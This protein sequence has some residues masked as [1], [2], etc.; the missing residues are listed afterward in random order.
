MMKELLQSLSMFITVSPE[1]ANEF[2]T[3]GKRNRIN[4]GIILHSSDKICTESHFIISGVLRIYSFRDDKEITEDF[5][6]PGEWCNALRSFMFQQHDIYN[7]E[8]ITDAEIVTI[9]YKDYTSILDQYIEVNKYIRILYDHIFF[10]LLD[11]LTLLRY[12]TAKEKYDIF[13][14]HYNHIQNDIPQYLIASFMGI[15]PET[16]S[17]VRKLK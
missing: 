15:T 13:C 5:N 11:R 7:V 8:A 14:K 2:I 3:K 6:G 9:D 16:L 12:S 17:R 10:R 4:K 1:L